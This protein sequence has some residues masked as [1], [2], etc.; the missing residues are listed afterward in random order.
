M[1]NRQ[2]NLLRWL[3]GKS[4]VVPLPD[5]QLDDQRALHDRG[6]VAINGAFTQITD[7]GRE[8]LGAS[9]VTSKERKG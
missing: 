7:V 8:A 9:A 5:H 3:S 6:Y 1:T 2:M 4:G